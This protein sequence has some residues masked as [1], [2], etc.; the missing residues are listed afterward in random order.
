MYTYCCIP[1]CN[2]YKK[3]LQKAYTRFK[4]EPPVK[5]H[6][7][8]C[9]EAM[10]RAISSL[11]QPRKYEITDQQQP[12]ILFIEGLTAKTFWSEEEFVSDI[13]L[14]EAHTQEIIREFEHVYNNVWPDNWLLNNTPTGQWAVFHLINQGIPIKKNCDICP[15]TYEVLQKLISRM[16]ENVFANASF[17]VIQTGTVISQ[18]FGP[19]NVRI[20]CHLGLRVSDPDMSYITVGGERGVWET[21]KCLLFDDSFLHEVQH[22]DI[23]NQARAVLLIDMWHPDLTETERDLVD[24]LFKFERAEIPVRSTIPVPMAPEL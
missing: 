18:H 4:K 11:N 14:L 21:G 6:T 7:E 5:T 19:T 3:I 10:Q 23:D 13:T 8:K 17:S 22:T 1:R 9:G 24:N 16:N 2:K 12:N 15:K 20:R